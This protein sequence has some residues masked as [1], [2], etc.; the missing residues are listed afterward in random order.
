MNFQSVEMSFS[1]SESTFDLSVFSISELDC[2]HIF[3]NKC[4]T[5]ILSF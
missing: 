5:E 2:I 3:E 1:I 4:L